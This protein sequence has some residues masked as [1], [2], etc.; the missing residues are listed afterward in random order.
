MNFPG[1]DRSISEKTIAEGKRF[2]SRY[3][4]NRRLGEFLKEL[5]LSEGHSKELLKELVGL[6]KLV[7]NGKTKGK[8]YKLKPMT[9]GKINNSSLKSDELFPM[10][11][12]EDEYLS[13][14]AAVYC[15]NHSMLL[16]SLDLTGS[17]II[18][19]AQCR[20]RLCVGFGYDNF[21]KE[22]FRV[23]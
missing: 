12:I 21:F 2:V 10:R 22:I 5:D 15:C 3:Y 19:Y 16:G 4:R 23:L 13:S 9:E 20:P 6:E 18:R 1:I 17:H 7:D 11:G 8:M 14:R